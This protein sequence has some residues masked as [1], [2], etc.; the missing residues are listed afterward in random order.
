MSDSS[1][2]QAAMVVRRVA[3]PPAVAPWPPYGASERCAFCNSAQD[4]YGDH[5]LCCKATGV[6]GRHIVLSDTVA[7]LLHECGCECRLEYPLPG[8][9][10]RP[11][12]VFA[13][14]FPGDS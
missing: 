14:S 7:D 9:L 2:P 13:L 10:L 4:D 12:D 3:D 5:V 1:F 8:T 11:A 6:Y